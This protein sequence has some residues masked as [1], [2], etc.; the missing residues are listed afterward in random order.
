L[1]HSNRERGL[2]PRLGEE[3]ALVYIGVG[4]I[5]AI[6]LIVLLLAFIF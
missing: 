3:A 1:P 2:G 6:I 5:V 4:T